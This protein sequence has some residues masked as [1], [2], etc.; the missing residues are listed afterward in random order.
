[1]L[2]IREESLVREWEWIVGLDVTEYV[3]IE[4]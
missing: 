2:S 4:L 1:M 3:R